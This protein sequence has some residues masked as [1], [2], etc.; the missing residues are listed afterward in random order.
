MPERYSLHAFGEL[1][2]DA[3]SGSRGF[4]VK[5]SRYLEKKLRGDSG[6]L[7]SVSEWADF[8][9]DSVADIYFLRGQ[10]FGIK[11]IDNLAVNP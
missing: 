9:T 3:V 6:W 11:A 7:T 4:S 2:G 1:S 10:P 5:T 8:A